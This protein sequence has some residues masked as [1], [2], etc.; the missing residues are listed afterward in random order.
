MAPPGWLVRRGQDGRSW[1]YE[2]A[3]VMWILKSLLTLLPLLALFTAAEVMAV[4]LGD[5]LILSRLGDPVEVEI[6]VLQWEDMDLDR[7]QITSASQQDYEVFNLVWLPVLEDLRFNL[8]GPDLDGAVRVLVSSRDPLNEPF[9]ELLL[10]L[11]W[12]GGS[13][14]REY[15]LLFDP[16]ETALP[17][18]RT[19]AVIIPVPEPAP[20]IQEPEPVVEPEPPIAAPLS[21]LKEPE[22]VQIALA[23]VQE[24]L[25][26]EA[27]PP[28][29]I[30]EEATPDARTQIAIEV[31]T[32]S[33][34]PPVVLDGTRLTYQV[35][36]G[37]SLW[38]IARQ[39]RPAGAGENLH[40][41]LLSLHNLNRSSFING[42]ISLLKA[43][44]VL[45]IPSAEDINLIDSLTAEA[46]FDRRWDEGTQR[47]DAAQR[48]EPIPMFAN[49]APAAEIDI[50]D[51]DDNLPLGTEAPAIGNGENALIMVSQTNTP[52]PLQLT[53]A[54][55]TE[56]EAGELPLLVP[57]SIAQASTQAG[58]VVR[59]VVQT[60]AVITAELE[61]EVTAMRMRHQS[62]EVIASQL[63]ATLQQAQLERAAR[64]SLLGRDNLLLV[65]SA[66][67]LFAALLASIVFSLKVAGDLRLRRMTS[68]SALLE[69]QAGGP[70]WSA[71]ERQNRRTERREPHLPDL[72]A[73][74]LF[75]P[76][77]DTG[78]TATNTNSPM[79]TAVSG[80]A[81]VPASGD[82]FDQ[83]DG[84]LAGDGKNSGKNA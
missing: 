56:A 31:E 42:N 34:R 68:G 73:G 81:G 49:I 62:A 76:I 83:M 71:A 61:S 15:V 82:L 16:P 5:E 26:A 27:T 79:R 11:R 60:R 40:Q 1:C 13:L 43:N 17:A 4:S 8:I 19:P 28:V 38:N 44:A 39:F 54:D 7:V 50:N 37:S 46:E 32:L 75:V 65:V 69:R 66:L 53:D 36:S 47:I 67:T 52:Q 22:P 21:E 18:V 63:S 20:V 10:V 35:R 23:P 24:P 77:E 84:L 9:L 29:V 80:T 41:M 58:V 74:E 51:A 78:T 2:M 45:Q 3:A 14:R 57:P 12:P 72:Y 48:G 64:E 30:E 70:V 59:Q 6:E 55:T 33:P 25:V